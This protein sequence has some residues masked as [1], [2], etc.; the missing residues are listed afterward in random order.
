MEAGGEG[1]GGVVDHD[2]ICVEEEGVRRLELGLLEEDLEFDGG[3]G[4]VGKIEMIGL[5]EEELER[6]MKREDKGKGKEK[7]KDLDVE[8]GDLERVEGGEVVEEDGGGEVE[9]DEDGVSE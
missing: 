8:E 6:V 3:K 5:L 4:K 1:V 9:E 2:R 7:E